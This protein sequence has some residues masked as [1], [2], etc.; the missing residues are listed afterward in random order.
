MQAPDMLIDVNYSDGEASKYLKNRVNNF[1]SYLLRQMK[2]SLSN[3]LLRR[4]PRKYDQCSEFQSGNYCQFAKSV[5]ICIIIESNVL[6]MQPVR[7]HQPDLG[8]GARPKG[9]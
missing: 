6:P 9:E 2:R 4:A 8:K 3:L 1:L 5:H 7:I